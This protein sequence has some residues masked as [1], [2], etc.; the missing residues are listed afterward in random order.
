MMQ[1]GIEDEGDQLRIMERV[2]RLLHKSP[3]QAKPQPMPLKLSANPDLLRNDTLTTLL[4][5]EYLLSSI[6]CKVKV[7]QAKK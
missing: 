7:E 4:A 3:E 2:K 5:D 1:L 6:G